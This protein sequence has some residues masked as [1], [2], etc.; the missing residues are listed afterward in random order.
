M[1]NKNVKVV[2]IDKQ[3][4]NMSKSLKQLSSSLYADNFDLSSSIFTLSSFVHKMLVAHNTGAPEDQQV[5]SNELS[6]AYDTVKELLG[7]QE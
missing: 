2:Q 4:E 5:I 6:R 3:L 1:S 7:P